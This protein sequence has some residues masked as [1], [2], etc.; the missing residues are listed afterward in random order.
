MYWEEKR[1]HTAYLVPDDIVDLAFGI[2]CRCLP[3]DH[4]YVLSQALQQALPWLRD[5]EDAG[6]HLIHGADS[7]NGWLRPEDPENGLLQLSR[8]TKLILRLP[9]GRVEAA[10]ALTGTTLDIADHPLT[11]GN[12]AVRPLS[13]TATLFSRYVVADPDEDEE[14]FLERAVGQLKGLGL[15]LRRLLCGKT[16]VLRTPEQEILTRSLMVAD[17]D[18]PG[19]VKLQQKGL[20]PGRKIGC[21]LFVPH[22]GIDPVRRPDTD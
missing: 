2:S 10:R 1:E 8:R 11:V 4:A 16:H 15:P 14:R 3:V 9:K 13:T 7:G 22:K 5:E 6:I 12:S 18:A 17:L 21:G 19:S 20:G